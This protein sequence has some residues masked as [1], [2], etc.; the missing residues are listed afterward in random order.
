MRARWI[1]WL[2]LVVVFVLIGGA[3]A[4]DDAPVSSEPIK[5][6]VLNSHHQLPRHARPRR[7]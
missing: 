7:Q 2:T 1:A 3:C 5:I 4:D 6:G